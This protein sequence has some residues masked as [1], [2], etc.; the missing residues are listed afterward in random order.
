MDCGKKKLARLWLSA[1][2]TKEKYSR[3]FIYDILEDLTS[4][5]DSYDKLISTSCSLGHNFDPILLYNVYDLDTH[6]R[7]YI[8]KELVYLI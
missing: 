3:L 8:F 7:S 1:C 4:W 6:W 2:S 5:P